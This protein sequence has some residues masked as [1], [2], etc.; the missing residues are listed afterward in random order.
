M[1]AELRN[2]VQPEIIRGKLGQLVGKQKAELAFL[3]GGAT[4]RKE[5]LMAFGLSG[6]LERIYREG[7]AIFAVPMSDE[8]FQDR[9]S[10]L[11]G[12]VLGELCFINEAAKAE[13]VLSPGNTL[14]FYEFL[15]PG[16]RVINNA[17]SLG[18]INGIS[19]PD[20][21][22]VD[23]DF[24]VRKVYEYTANGMPDYYREKTRHFEG[25]KRDFPDIFGESEL[26]FIRPLNDNDFPKALGFPIEYIPLTYNQLRNYAGNLCFH[27][28]TDQD[29]ASLHEVQQEARKQLTRGRRYMSEHTPL[30][31]QYRRY[32][33]RFGGVR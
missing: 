20:G 8:E 30:T 12:G 24:I 29:A 33:E 31:P 5:L 11:A 7:V 3:V 17:F 32:L 26:R 18:A 2:L 14:E 4:G 10:N 1:S 15:F 9:M 27:H 23:D 13:T 22:L 21:L 16:R 25:R 6:R 28:R 19:V